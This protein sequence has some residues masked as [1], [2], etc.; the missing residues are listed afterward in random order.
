[1]ACSIFIVK[2]ATTVLKGKRPGRQISMTRVNR[3]LVVRRAG[4]ISDSWKKRRKNSNT[5]WRKW[6]AHYEWYFGGNC[7]GKRGVGEN[8]GIREGGEKPEEDCSAP[9]TQGEKFLKKNRK[10]LKRGRLMAWRGANGERST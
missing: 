7:L 9:G 5:A 4:A 6:L 8:K 3:R 2:K 1:M 10:L